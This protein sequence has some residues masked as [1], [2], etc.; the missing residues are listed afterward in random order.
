MYAVQTAMLHPHHMMHMHQMQ[1]IQYVP[2]MNMGY[3]IQHPEFIYYQQPVESNPSLPQYYLMDLYD[4]NNNF[5]QITII[6]PFK[7]YRNSGFQCIIEND[8]NLTDNQILYNQNGC[9]YCFQKMKS[10]NQFKNCFI[11]CINE[12][13][14]TVSYQLVQEK[15]VIIETKNEPELEVVVE[16]QHSPKISISLSIMSRRI[17]RFFHFIINRK[18]AP[19]IITRFFKKIS[20]QKK[21]YELILKKEKRLNKKLREMEL[22][23]MRAEDKKIAA[24]KTKEEINSKEINNFIDKEENS[25][26]PV[27][28]VEEPIVSN[29]IE[30]S[31][32][33]KVKRSKKKKQTVSSS[34]SDSDDFFDEIHHITEGNKIFKTIFER[35]CGKSSSFK[36]ILIRQSDKDIEFIQNECILCIKNGM[37]KEQTIEHVFDRFD[38]FYSNS[39]LIDISIFEV[40][41]TVREIFGFPKI[42][43]EEAAKSFEAFNTY[44]SFIIHLVLGAFIKN[45]NLTIEMSVMSTE[46]HC[47]LITSNFI[48]DNAIKIIIA[49]CKE[50]ILSSNI[51][52]RK[53]ITMPPVDVKDPFIECVLIVCSDFFDLL[54]NLT[55]IDK[56]TTKKCYLINCMSIFL[57]KQ[58]YSEDCLNFDLC[59][60]KL[61]NKI[62]KYKDILRTPSFEDAKS[63]SFYECRILMR[64][65]FDITE[66]DWDSKNI[67]VKQNI[68]EEPLRL[69]DDYNSEEFKKNLTTHKFSDENKEKKM[70]IISI[71]QSYDS[72]EP[73]PIPGFIE[74]KLCDAPVTT[75]VN[76]SV[77]A[78]ITAPVTTSINSEFK[79]S[80]TNYRDMV[81]L[82]KKSELDDTKKMETKENIQKLIEFKKYNESMKDL[83]IDE[84]K[85]L[86]DKFKQLPINEFVVELNRLK[87]I[88]HPDKSDI[89]HVV[90]EKKV[91]LT[92]PQINLLADI[93]ITELKINLCPPEITNTFKNTWKKLYDMSFCGFGGNS[94]REDIFSL[95]YDVI[96]MTSIKLNEHYSCLIDKMRNRLDETYYDNFTKNMIEVRHFIYVIISSINDPGKEKYVTMQLSKLVNKFVLENFNKRVSFNVNF[97]SGDIDK[98]FSNFNKTI[99]DNCSIICKK[100]DYMLEL[101]SFTDS[102]N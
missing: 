102:E 1:E 28:P 74:L 16:I 53:Y 60:S 33:K 42:I 98:L 70:D 14:Q 37:N 29:I 83:S 36:N 34:D 57:N 21:Q 46:N 82:K 15:E 54:N 58:M 71:V 85:Y 93:I 43:K 2:Q 26:K 27:L 55:K 20:F 30:L 67:L 68:I 63:N 8:D 17:T 80:V 81:L 69:R 41:K 12:P 72:N 7:L 87:E 35:L 31:P 78:S 52:N 24:L 38:I 10:F 48:F 44:C 79:N 73:P 4:N 23:L 100:Y 61:R 76:A 86:F 66:N 3:P 22:K 32:K 90:K 59:N 64:M 96:L 40:K 25:V 11:Y 13:V 97:L 75:P 89:V 65:Y 18:K 5:Y 56:L 51:V 77:T 19:F 84:K 95:Y 101:D 47:R 91:N 45:K 9:K 92:E 49:L 88:L 6:R 94:I 50:K 99:E 39:Q 62:I